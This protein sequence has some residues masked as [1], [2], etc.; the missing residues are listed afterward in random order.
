MA[1]PLAL[2]WRSAAIA[3]DSCW[4][5]QKAWTKPGAGT[6]V[7]SSLGWHFFK[8][9]DVMG[10]KSEYV[11]YGNINLTFWIFVFPS[12]FVPK[13]RVASV[14]SNEV[15]TMSWLELPRE[16]NQSLFSLRATLH[17]KKLLSESRVFWKSGR[18]HSRLDQILFA[19]NFR[20]PNK[21]R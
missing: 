17:A 13:S 11:K 15:H 10:N 19:H 5:A 4:L 14:A 7:A 20:G 2:Q 3:C 21:V 1:W 12:S 8:S 16:F 9:Q 6:S 18:V